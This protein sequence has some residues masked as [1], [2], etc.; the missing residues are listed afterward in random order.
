REL[1]FERLAER[2]LRHLR[3]ELQTLAM[4]PVFTE[5]PNML[6]SRRYEID[7]H[8]SQMKASVLDKL[9]GSGGKLEQI[10]SRL[11]PV[12]LANKLG[13]NKTML[14][15][16]T[17]RQA[18]AARIVAEAQARTLGNLAAKLDSLSPLSVLDRG[19][20][21]TQLGDGRILRNA[22]DATKG[23]K[24]KIR[25]ANGKLEAEVLSSES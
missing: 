6:G 20:S 22:S 2:Q 4:S 10:A 9:K 17:Q 8:I 25:L 24:L 3:S 5:F 12:R 16:L 13:Q 23:D 14:A 1:L 15:V 19:Y 18:A 21:I 11:S 7:D